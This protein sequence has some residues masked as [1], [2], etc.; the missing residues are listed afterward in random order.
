MPKM[1]YCSSSLNPAFSIPTSSCQPGHS[2]HFS[3]QSPYFDKCGALASGE[4]SNDTIFGPA[5]CEWKLAK[6]QQQ[7]GSHFNSDYT[8]ISKKTNN[9]I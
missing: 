2:Y 1:L 9:S 7:H 4:D 8:D 6:H 5:L 3:D